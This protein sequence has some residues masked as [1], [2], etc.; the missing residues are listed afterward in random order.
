MS[1]Q[2]SLLRLGD[3]YMTTFEPHFLCEA[4]DGTIEVYRQALE[5]WKSLTTDPLLDAIDNLV[6]AT[7][8][9]Q[10]AK[11]AWRGKTISP[12]TV[13]KLLRAINAVLAKAGPPGPR[14]RDA[15]GWIATCP[16]ARSLKCGRKKPRPVPL[17]VLGKIYAACGVAVAPAIA[18]VTPAAW[19]RALIVTASQVAVR[20]GG[21]FELLWDDIDLAAATLR[22]DA[23]SD[24]CDEERWKPLKE[25]VVR[26]LLTIRSPSAKVFAWPYDSWRMFYREW[27][28]IQEAAGV[29]ASKHFKFHALKATC[30]T[31][32]ARVGGS[33]AVRVMLDH[34]SISTSEWYVD[35]TESMREVIERV[36]H[37]VEFDG[38]CHGRE[39]LPQL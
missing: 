7:F 32:V 14:N 33:H 1:L 4:K 26:H 9:T 30:G 3:F 8:R 27:H 13:N 23:E 2:R 17:D 38:L 28:S 19:W 36:A 18:G 16:W 12:A 11:R 29:P 20:R 25:V 37:P 6:V 22:V 31:Q 24:K 5:L 35:A 34:S 39:T 21:L 15:L 10:L